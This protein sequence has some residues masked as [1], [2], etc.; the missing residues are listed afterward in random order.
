[1]DL[2][3]IPL[4]TM[5]ERTTTLN[6]YAGQVV[7]VVNVASRCGL[8]GQYEQLEELHRTY[9]DR[10]FTVLGFPSN[11]FLQ[12]LRSNEAV[13]Q[14]CSTTYGITFPVFD[15]LRVNGRNEHPLYTE[16]KKTKDA[17]GKA[18]R[19]RWNFEKFL[20]LPSGQRLRFRPRT[21]PDAPE[22]IAAIEANLPD[23]PPTDRTRNQP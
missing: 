4:T 15:R 7:M 13:L 2:T 21:T 9:A 17:T 23:Q 11:Q 12:E 18:G 16:L 5:D 19:V 3:T 14:Y 8:S 1:M 22:I 20:L 10:G 6:D